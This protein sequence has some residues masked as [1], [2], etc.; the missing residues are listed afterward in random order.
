MDNRKQLGVFNFRWVLFVA[1]FLVVSMTLSSCEPLRKK[2]TRKKKADSAES[3]EVPIL[4][5]VAYP[6]KV[7]TS[8]DLYKNHFTYWKAWHKE[9][10]QSVADNQGTKR[11]LYL[12]AQDVTQ[13][14]EMQKLLPEE[15]QAL[16]KNAIDRLA[17][18]RADVVSPV[19]SRDASAWKTELESI[20]KKIRR[21]Y[22]VEKMQGSF[23]P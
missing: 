9:L 7:Y 12:L 23:Q 8:L 11:K 17:R 13:L 18:F 21:D 20:D 5:P 2:F 6:K 19:P 16:L 14:T 22:S 1:F 4:E 3:M 15:K 10:M